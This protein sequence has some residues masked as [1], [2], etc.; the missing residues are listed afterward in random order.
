MQMRKTYQGEFRCSG[1]GKVPE[2][3]RSRQKRAEGAGGGAAN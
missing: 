3:A 1:Q 2:T